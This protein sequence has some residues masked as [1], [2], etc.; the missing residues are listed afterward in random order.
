MTEKTVKS[1]RTV[2]TNLPDS[3]F[4]DFTDSGPKATVEDLRQGG[5][6]RQRPAPAYLKVNGCRSNDQPE[7][8]GDAATRGAAA[9]RARRG[10]LI[11]SP[12][13]IEANR[14]L[15]VLRRVRALHEASFSA[16]FGEVHAL[17]GENGAGKSTMIKI[18]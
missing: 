10:G 11:G 14:H 12:R 13:A 17:V 15:P 2:F 7:R 5:A 1:V 8:D 6:D 16:D 3:F 9:T 4:A 18:L